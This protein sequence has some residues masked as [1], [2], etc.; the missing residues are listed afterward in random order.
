MLQQRMPTSGVLSDV[1]TRLKADNYVGS[2][3]GIQG[4]DGTQ[5]A[6]DTPMPFKD[7]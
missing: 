4:T 5:I 1:T 6:I 2:N 3:T 7:L